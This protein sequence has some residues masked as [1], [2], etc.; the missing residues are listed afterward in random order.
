MPERDAGPPLAA[1]SAAWLL[2]WVT[3]GLVF[4][5]MLAAAVAV[6]AD[7]TAR[8]LAAAPHAI[9]IVVPAGTDLAPLVAALRAVE[10]VAQA[11]PIG[12]PGRGGLPPPDAEDRRPR[13][14]DLGFVPGQEPDL[15]ALAATLN[16]AVPVATIVDAGA[17]R[18][19]DRQLARAVGRLAAACS[20]L[21]LFLLLPAVAILAGA[22]LAQQQGTLSLLQVLGASDPQLARLLRRQAL[23]A[24]LRG[25]LLGAAA[26]LMT[27]LGFAA[28]GLAALRYLA[29]EPAGWLLIGA[30]PLAAGLVVVA[31]ASPAVGRGL[32]RLDVRRMPPPDH[33]ST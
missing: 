31:A 1:T 12:G 6:G 32:A 7:G 29:I 14:I 5:A 11:R 2:A 3:G 27:I 25:G 13:L 16:A 15:A 9:T 4:L 28:A 21:A 8:R 10:G 23:G 24:A 33:A 20:A 17:Q 26:A 19:R 22:S 30:V 18:A